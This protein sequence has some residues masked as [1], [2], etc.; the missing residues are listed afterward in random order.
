MRPGR[1]RDGTG[2]VTVTT[3]CRPARKPRTNPSGRS[4]SWFLRIVCER[5]GKERMISATQNAHGEMLIR[6]I[7]G[8][9]RHDGGGGRVATAELLTGLE[10]VSSRPVRRIVLV[11]R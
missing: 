3:R 5:C 8:R 2:A 7:I 1:S 11:E 9:M 4:P 6:D 10:C